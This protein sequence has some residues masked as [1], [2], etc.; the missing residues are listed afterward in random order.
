VNSVSGCIQVK[1]CTS[2]ISHASWW[3]INRIERSSNRNGRG[4][5]KFLRLL[6]WP[7]NTYAM[8]QFKTKMPALS[9]PWA[10]RRDRKWWGDDR[11]AT[12][13][14]LSIFT[15][16]YDCFSSTL[17]SQ[18]H[19]VRPILKSFS[20]SDQTCMHRLWSSDMTLSSVIR[21][22]DPP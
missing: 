4:S 1:D 8:S 9:H 18:R 6:Y 15:S 17:K 3:R 12:T 11:N 5:L 19:H 16:P 10:S 7:H 22:R 14:V 21:I 20:V 2:G 13:L